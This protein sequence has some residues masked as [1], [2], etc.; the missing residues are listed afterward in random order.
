MLLVSVGL[1]RLVTGCAEM[2]AL[3]AGLQALEND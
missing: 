1:A 3:G 2:G